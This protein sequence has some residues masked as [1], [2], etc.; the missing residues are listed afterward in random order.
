M[1]LN[2]KS[3]TKTPLAIF[4]E[5]TDVHGR[6]FPMHISAEAAAYLL[7]HQDEYIYWPDP[8]SYSGALAEFWRQ[9]GLTP[10][11]CEYRAFD[12]VRHIHHI[13]VAI[14]CLPEREK[15]LVAQSHPPIVT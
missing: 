3:R 4:V 6:A 7:L 8:V 11:E 9:Q 12:S 15:G 1:R 10:A 5:V 14:E 2:V 13:F